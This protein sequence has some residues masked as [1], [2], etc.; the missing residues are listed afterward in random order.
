M[1]RGGRAISVLRSLAFGGSSTVVPLLAE[2]SLATIPR[3][4]ADYVVTEY[5]IAS[6][7]GKSHRERANELIAIAHPDHRAELKKEARRLFYP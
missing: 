3:Q 4:F 5:G 1:A 7:A 6:L 2:G